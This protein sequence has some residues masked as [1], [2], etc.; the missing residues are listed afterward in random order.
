MKVV[1]WAQPERFITLTQ[2]PAE[3]AALRAKMRKLS[4]RLRQEGYDVEWAWCV[5][6]GGRTGMKHVHALQHGGFIPQRLLQ[7]RWG[8]IVHISAVRH[9]SAPAKYALK[10]AASKYALKGAQTATGLSVHL[11]LN[12]GRGVHLSRSYLHGKTT[13]E[14]EA[15]LNPT[16]PDL[17]WV[18]VPQG[19]N[20]PYELTH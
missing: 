14:V 10:G 17:T 3:W 20:L 6:R 5:E 1:E 18:L 8:S 7:D 19:E 4:W 12:G 15:L 2:A 9:G 16:D 11:D 13:A